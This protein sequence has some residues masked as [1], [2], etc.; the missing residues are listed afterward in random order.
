MFRSSNGERECMSAGWPPRPALILSPIEHFE[1]TS[2][3]NL[4]AFLSEKTHVATERN[5]CIVRL[6][7]TGGIQGFDFSL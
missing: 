4:F 5:G 2:I 3:N 6:V 1:I 7:D